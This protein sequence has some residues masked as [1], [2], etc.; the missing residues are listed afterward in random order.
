MIKYLILA[1]FVFWNTIATAQT[2]M[3]IDTSENGE[4]ITKISYKSFGRRGFGAS[5]FYYKGSVFFYDRFEQGTFQLS[6][7]KIQYKCPILFNLLTN[8]LIAKTAEKDIVLQN[9]EFTLLNHHFI[10]IN[11]AYY[12]LIVDG[13]TKILK[14]YDC[15]IK[16]LSRGHGGIYS[17]GDGGFDG[18][19]IRKELYFLK[20]GTQQPKAFMMDKKWVLAFINKDS[21]ALRQAVVELNSET[22]E[23]D[24][25]KILKH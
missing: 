2:E 23:A 20:S 21:T 15:Q 22:L 1:F 6:D 10:F 16:P 19:I 3:M 13:P 8:E 18:K 7:S 24:L 17:S 4:I 5:P 9:V 25:V 12:E 11:N 14:K